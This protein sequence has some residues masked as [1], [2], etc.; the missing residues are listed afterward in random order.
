MLN[1]P[2]ARDASQLD[3][4]FVLTTVHPLATNK[5]W[6]LELVDG[7][8]FPH[9]IDIMYHDIRINNLLLSDDSL[10]LVIGNLEGYWENGLAPEAA[11]Y[12]TFP[13]ECGRMESTAALGSYIVE[14]CTLAVLAEKLIV[15][16]IHDRAGQSKSKLGSS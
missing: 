2:T 12:S 10:R 14:A 1:Q 15:D 4:K 16:E 6:T 7:L 8:R 13:H 5:S 9:S 3:G 11:W